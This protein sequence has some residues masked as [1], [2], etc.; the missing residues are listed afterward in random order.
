MRRDGST[1]VPRRRRPRRRARGRARRRRRAAARARAPPRGRRSARRSARRPRCRVSASAVWR[2]H[3]RI[4]WSHPGSPCRR[5]IEAATSAGLRTQTITRRPGTTARQNGSTSA[6]RGSLK[7][8]GERAN[9]SPT[10]AAARARGSAK[11]GSR[12]QPGR[13]GRRRG[14]VPAEHRQELVVERDER[15]L[16]EVA[17]RVVLGVGRD[18][19]GLVAEVQ[20][21]AHQELREERGAGAVH[22]GDAHAGE[23]GVAGRPHATAV[24]QLCPSGGP[25]VRRAR[26]IDGEGAS[27]AGRSWSTASRC[28]ACPSTGPAPS[29]GRRRRGPGGRAC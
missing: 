10:S 29:R 21:H 20:A 18:E 1:S 9:V 16:L 2:S 6:A 13:G 12:S 14:D 3:I 11:R 5:S 24:E 23:L 26:R 28:P 22:A 25:V 19:R 17:V 4:Q 15:R 8:H 27:R 7:P